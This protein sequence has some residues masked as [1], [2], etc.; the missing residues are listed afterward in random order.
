MGSRASGLLCLLAV[1]VSGPSAAQ[2]SSWPQFRGNPRLTGI[3]SADVPATLS[4]KW[5]YQAG[6]TI[7]S[8]AS[9]VDGAVYV[10]AGNGDLLSIDL[11]SGKLRWK[12]GTA[13]QIGESSPAVDGL[14]ADVGT[15]N[16][17]VVA[18]NLRTKRIVWRYRDPDREFP[19]YSSAALVDGRL[20]VGGRDKAVH[21][22]DAATGKGAWKFATRARVDSSPAVAGGRVF[23]GSSDGKFYVLDAQTGRK[24]W[25]YEVGD[26]LTASPAIAGGRI[27]I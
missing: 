14:H 2:P 20:I 24:T 15:F 1:C 7:E 19:Y 25:E 9:I 18:V 11:A 8:S 6:E 22:I 3:A 21:A 10:G 27:G 17:D 16:D 23:V 4:L 26:A 13:S 5:T 12:Y